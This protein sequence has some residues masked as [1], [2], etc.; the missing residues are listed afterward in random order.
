M[1]VISKA[2]TRKGRTRK[3]KEASTFGG[4][5][6][7]AS[8]WIL[9]GVNLLATLFVVFLLIGNYHGLYF[10]RKDTMVSVPLDP[11]TGLILPQKPLSVLLEDSDNVEDAVTVE[12]G[13]VEEGWL[14]EEEGKAEDR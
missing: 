4:D 11:G 6:R 13:S 14:G 1:R 9:G 7:E 2:K 8:L 12:R 5:W 3:T 10:I